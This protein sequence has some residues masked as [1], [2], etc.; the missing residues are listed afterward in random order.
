MEYKL[1]YYNNFSINNDGNQQIKNSKHT[2][3]KKIRLGYFLKKEKIDVD[4]KLVV[5]KNIYDM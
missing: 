4:K 2:E 5:F 1:P 3:W